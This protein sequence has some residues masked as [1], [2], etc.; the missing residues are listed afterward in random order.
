MSTSGVFA[1]VVAAI[2]AGA[3]AWRRMQG[4]QSAPALGDAPQIP[5]A[6]SP[7]AIPTLQMPTC[8]GERGQCAI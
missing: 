1:R 6:K 3:V 2:G 4:A 5:A 7:G 8:T